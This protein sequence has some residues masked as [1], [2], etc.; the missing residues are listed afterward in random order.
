MKLAV[1]LAG[2]TSD[3]HT[4]EQ[5]QDWQ[6]P[7]QDREATSND[8]LAAVAGALNRV[9]TRRGTLSSWVVGNNVRLGCL[10]E[11]MGCQNLQTPTHLEPAALWTAASP[12]PCQPHVQVRQGSSAAAQAEAVQATP[13]QQ[14]WLQF[15]MHDAWADPDSLPMGGFRSASQVLQRERGCLQVFAGDGRLLEEGDRL[16]LAHH[17]VQV[18]PVNAMR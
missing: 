2:D 15:T 6:G 3:L 10:D 18:M 16:V 12:W 14:A 1:I 9:S 11:L 7:E 17:L 8:E 13:V 5:L 4:V